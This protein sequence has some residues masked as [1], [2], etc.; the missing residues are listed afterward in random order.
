[1]FSDFCSR[2]SIE[3]QRFTYDPRPF[4]VS[5][6]HMDWTFCGHS[7]VMSS[8][9]DK[10]SP[11]CSVQI[12]SSLAIFFQWLLKHLSV[13][14]RVRRKVQSENQQSVPSPQC[15]KSSDRERDVALLCKACVL[16]MSVCVYEHMVRANI[17]FYLSPDWCG[18]WQDKYCIPFSQSSSFCTLTEVQRWSWG[19]GYTP[20][21]PQ[22]AHPVE[23]ECSVPHQQVLG[24]LFRSVFTV[25][26]H[27]KKL[28][29]D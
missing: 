1:M 17:S 22:E 13:S 20:T 28:V 11:L 21:T 27:F 16:C 2:I 29:Q 26:L 19:F 15:E 7:E 8:V 10:N 6:C 24:I 14:A 4:P 12:S 25:E 18:N 3:L 23:L 5:H 9:L